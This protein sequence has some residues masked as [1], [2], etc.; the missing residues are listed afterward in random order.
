MAW[1]KDLYELCDKA[2]EDLGFDKGLVKAVISHQFLAIRKL[3]TEKV[4][5]RC[6][7]PG[8]GTYKIK[9]WKMRR[10]VLAVI[11][12]YKRGK[13]SYE[14]AKTR[15]EELLQGRKRM[16]QSRHNS[17]KELVRRKRVLLQRRLK[18]AADKATQS[19]ETA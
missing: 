16:E 14:S 19:S 10:E 12:A 7:I 17:D 6:M 3:I 13:D 5:V 15:V 9:D 18:A 8:L 4:G 2:A 11:D 1:N